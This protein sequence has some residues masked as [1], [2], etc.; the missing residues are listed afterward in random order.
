MAKESI[1]CKHV[2]SHTYSGALSLIAKIKHFVCKC[3]NRVAKLIQPHGHQ[4]M[5]LQLILLYA[6]H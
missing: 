5:A 1:S 3:G 4:I 6:I 2:I